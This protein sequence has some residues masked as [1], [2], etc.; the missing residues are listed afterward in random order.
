MPITNEGLPRG[1][2]AIAWMFTS[3]GTGKILF[4]LIFNGA[5]LPGLFATDALFINSFIKTVSYR[6]LCYKSV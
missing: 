4:V 1:I 6:R 3:I 5:P 2:A